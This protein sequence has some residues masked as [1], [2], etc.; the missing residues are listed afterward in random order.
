MS[1]GY[2]PKDHGVA[3]TAT[4]DTYVGD[5]WQLQCSENMAWV[6][7]AELHCHSVVFRSFCQMMQV[8]TTWIRQAETYCC[9]VTKSHQLFFGRE[10]VHPV[11][12]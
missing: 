10:D 2:H 1:S 7:R 12:L 11:R 6:G 9:C 5:S 4:A 3:S 8:N